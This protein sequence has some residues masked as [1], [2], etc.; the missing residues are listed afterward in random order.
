MRQRQ[1][2]DEGEENAVLI[3]I[4]SHHTQTQAN[5]GGGGGGPGT[6]PSSAP[7]TSCLASWDL[8]INLERGSAT[9]AGVML[10][11]D[12]VALVD[13]ERGTLEV[14]W[15]GDDGAGEV[16]RRVGGPMSGFE[17][18]E[19]TNGSSPPLGTRSRRRR[20]SIEEGTTEEDDDEDDEEEGS[21]WDMSESGEE[22]AEQRER[23]IQLR[24]LV[25]HSC[26]E[27]Y[28]EPGGEVL[29]TRVYRR[30]E[31]RGVGYQPRVMAY[32]GSCWLD[33]GEAWEMGSMWVE[34]GDDDAGTTT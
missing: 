4:G 28:T 11:P 31:E 21:D 27:I 32:G 3:D 18:F 10:S 22:G 8:T 30:D 26:V 23:P 33:R 14:V 25:D 1:L 6:T 19:T 29:S 2:I 24:I 5:G 15:Q 9:A 20:R 13:W 17:T 7:V 34:E 16:V 12:A